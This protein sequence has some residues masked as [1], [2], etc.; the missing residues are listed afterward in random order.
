MT[1]A[2]ISS[3]AN[4]KSNLWSGVSRMTIPAIRTGGRG[5][6]AWSLP[7]AEKMT[8]QPQ[9]GATT[10][11]NQVV[12]MAAHRHSNVLNESEDARLT[13]GTRTLN[14]RLLGLNVGSMGRKEVAAV[15]AAARLQRA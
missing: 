9:D 4:V 12:R 3:T 13:G 10:S 1:H 15:S 5:G 11:G 6:T 14:R 7:N 2:E 8:R